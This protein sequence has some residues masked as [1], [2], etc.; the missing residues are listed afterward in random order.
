MLSTKLLLFQY[1]KAKNIYLS[2]LNIQKSKT[3]S[4]FAEKRRCGYTWG[5]ITSQ[6]VVLFPVSFFLLCGLIGCTNLSGVNVSNIRDVEPQRDKDTT[7][8]LQGKVANLIPL[9]EGQVYQLQDTSGTIWVLTTQ[10]DLQPGNEVLLKGKVR[11]KS[12]P[13]A[14]KDFGEVYIEEQEQLERKQS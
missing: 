9:V 1:Q 4:I 6:N 3:K 8:Y 2:C 11:Y 10:T 5:P 12:I 13:L 14:G 7:V